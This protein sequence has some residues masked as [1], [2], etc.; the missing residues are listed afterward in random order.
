MDWK[1]SKRDTDVLVPELCLA[2]D[3]LPLPCFPLRKNVGIPTAC[4]GWIWPCDGGRTVE[5]W[6]MALSSCR[7][8]GQNSSD[9]QSSLCFV[10]KSCLEKRIFGMELCLLLCQ[11]QPPCRVL[12][13][14]QLR[15]GRTF[16][17]CLDLVADVLGIWP[18]RG[19][20]RVAP[21]HC[22][23]PKV[24]WLLVVGPFTSPN[25]L[26]FFSFE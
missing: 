20:A 16:P 8:P 22:W 7:L 2:C 5:L 14:L 19:C 9:I 10:C 17:G 4:K 26:L 18:E 1:R 12:C 15:A 21:G 3:D 24:V 6:E 13:R 11:Q 25:L 23:E